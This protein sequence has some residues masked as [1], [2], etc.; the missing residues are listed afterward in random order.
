MAI[1]GK[2]NR[3]TLLKCSPPSTT[4]Q[5]CQFGSE[6]SLRWN[7]KKLF[8]TVCGLAVGGISAVIYTLENSVKAYD[9]PLHPPKF[10][11]SHNGIFDAY[12]AESI[13]RGFK[14]YRQ[15]C[16]ACHSL[17]FLPFRR[18][19]DVAFSEKEMRDIA[20]EYEI[21]DGPNDS[22]EMFKRPGK[23]NDYLPAPYP[24][25]DAAAAANNGAAPPDLSLIV[26]G[27]EGNEDYIFSLL[28]GYIESENIPAGAEV[29]DTS[30]YNPY[31]QGSVIAMA[32]PLYNNIIEYDDGTPASRS[33]LAKDVV[34]FLAWCA[35]PE[36][37]KRKLWCIK[38]N[39]FGV[40]FMAAFWYVNRHKW[41]SLKARQVFFNNLK[42]G[43]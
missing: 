2:L 18:L 28:T 40:L 5:V 42:K 38:L 27:R 6:A 9:W 30:H 43:K 24:N 34:T 12:D 23:I 3:M 11:W 21:V 25:E 29:S 1:V 10:P 19:I 32:P 26:L 37:D 36:A 7:T 31:F 22:G 17:N 41:T 33:Q 8:Y 35:S 14:V 20:A 16:S 15:V 4:I 13:R 39:M